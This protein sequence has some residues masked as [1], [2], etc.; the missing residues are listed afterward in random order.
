MGFHTSLK[1][2]Y[3]RLK[4]LASNVDKQMET[5]TNRVHQVEQ[6]LESFLTPTNS[7]L[8][9]HEEKIRQLER[10]L[11]QEREERRRDLKQERQHRRQEPV[12]LEANF[13]EKLRM[14]GA[15]IDSVASRM[16][17]MEKLQS[18]CCTIQSTNVPEGVGPFATLTAKFSSYMKKIVE[19]EARLESFRF[20][21]ESL[22]IS[23]QEVQ[24]SFTE[25]S[26]KVQTSGHEM[27]SRSEKI[28]VACVDMRR[29][30][31]GVDSK[32]FDTLKGTVGVRSPSLQPT[33]PL[34]AQDLQQQVRRLREEGE[35]LG[36]RIS[37]M[38]LGIDANRN[39]I[40]R[41]S[42]H[43]MRPAG[44]VRKSA[45]PLLWDIL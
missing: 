11:V 31:D 27:S 7:V 37:G 20:K 6:E 14:K 19:P 28:C 10:E 38:Q 33:M 30:L 21:H 41:I 12:E 42:K 34:V 22:S 17:Q 43:E 36:S 45:F 24:H 32:S 9:S 26:S 44:T 5:I 18:T 39:A 35:N 25:L 40:T 13:L 29:K 15:L 2:S 23:T 3:N 16:E 1:P 4:E 8:Q